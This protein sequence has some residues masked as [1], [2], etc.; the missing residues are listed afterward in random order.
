M[1]NRLREAHKSSNQRQPSMRVE[2]RVAEINRDDEATYTRSKAQS[3]A[4][5]AVYLPLH[6]YLKNRYADIVVLAFGEIEDL[7]GCPLPEAARLQPSW[8]TNAA[9]GAAP[10]AQARSW[11]QADRTAN[12]NLKAQRVVFERRH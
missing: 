8:W 1:Q 7:L 4:V 6:K 11:T 10:S 12:A 5:P 9:A 3:D 2:A